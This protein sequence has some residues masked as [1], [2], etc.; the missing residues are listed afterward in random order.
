MRNKVKKLIKDFFIF[1]LGSLGSKVILFLLV[2]LYTSFLSTEE[3]GIA[4][5]IFTLTQVLVPIVSLSIWQGVIRF[6]LSK[7]QKK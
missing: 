3:Y 6:G 5:L 4:D 7:N 1:A 2:P